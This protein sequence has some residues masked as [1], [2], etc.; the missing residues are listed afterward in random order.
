MYDGPLSARQPNAIWMV[1]RW[2]ANSDPILRDYWVV[3]RTCIH[4]IG[5]SRTDT[6]DRA[7]LSVETSQFLAMDVTAFLAHPSRRLM[8]ELIEYQSF[9]RP[10]VRQHFQTSSPLKPLDQLNISFIWRLLRMRE[11][12]L[13]Q[14]VLVT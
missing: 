10:S 8:G 9:R 12:K 11:R 14:M 7:I 6:S 3:A 5:Y 2:R 13:V 1:F 4:L